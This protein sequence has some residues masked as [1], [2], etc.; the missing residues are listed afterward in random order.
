M[1]RDSWTSLGLDLGQVADPTAICVVE[2]VEVETDR[3]IHSQQWHAK[4]FGRCAP[5]PDCR[6]DTAIHY[7]VRALGRLPLN[8]GYVDVAAHVSSVVHSLNKR[9]AEPHLVIDATGVGRPVVDLIRDAVR[10]LKARVTAAVLTGGDKFDGHERSLEWRVPKAHLVSRLQ[11]LLSS[12][13]LFLP[14]TKEA[15]ALARELETFEIRITEDARFTAGAFKT[16]AH[17]DLV[18]A[19]GLAVLRDQRSWHPVRGVKVWK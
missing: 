1:E 16:G 12:K 8:T 2:A 3:V 15:K 5:A 18:T 17:D 14:D 4:H 10:D 6:Y 11:A 19:L 9:G 7:F 13:R